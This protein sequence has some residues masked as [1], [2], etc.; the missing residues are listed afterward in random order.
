MID[1]R[2]VPNGSGEHCLDMRR[3][4]RIMRKILV[5]DDEPCIREICSQYLRM[6]GYQ[7]DTSASGEEALDA[8]ACCPYDL[9][10]LDLRMHGLS[11][12]ATL[13]RVYSI[14]PD[15]RALFV[16]GSIREFE[17]EL[18]DARAKGLFGVLAK[19]FALEDL[20]ALV[21]SA[22]RDGIRAA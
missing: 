15:A 10:I 22:L 12:L 4:F 1:G 19:P 21:E 9:L 5:V 14:K 7:V 8:V 18:A 16:S 2:Q 3:G 11:G 13:E 20:S 6:A 17:S